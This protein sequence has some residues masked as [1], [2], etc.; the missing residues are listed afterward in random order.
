M[1]DGAVIIFDDDNGDDE[2]LACDLAA[3]R[4]FDPIL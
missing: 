2:G 3:V 4:F 1:V